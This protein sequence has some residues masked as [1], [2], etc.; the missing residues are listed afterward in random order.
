MFKIQVERTFIS[1]L[2]RPYSECVEDLSSYGSELYDIFVEQGKEYTQSDCFDICFQKYLAQ[3]CKCVDSGFYPLIGQP[4]C[5]N[6][7]QLLCDFNE[8][9][10]FYSEI[11]IKT[12]CG[13]QCPLE[14]KSQN[15]D[16]SISSFKYPTPAY[17][18]QL[19][20]HSNILDRFVPNVS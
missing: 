1:K 2:E 10:E 12:R 8:F 6:T 15:F 11:D 14:C 13:T 16:I 18:D 3:K 17:T 4:Y 7:T 20:N 19:V 9:N 5:L